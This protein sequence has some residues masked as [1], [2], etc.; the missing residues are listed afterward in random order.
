ML[1]CGRGDAESPAVRLPGMPGCPVC[2]AVRYVRLSGCPAARYA[3]LPGISGCPAAR[4]ARLPGMSGCPVC[5]AVRLP[6]CP[7]CPAVR[8]ARLSGCPA[9]RYARLFD[10]A[11][12]VEGSPTLSFSGAAGGFRRLRQVTARD[13][14]VKN[15]LLTGRA[16]G[17]RCEPCWAAG[18]TKIRH[19]WL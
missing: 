9:A 7:V 12:R 2:P 17:V 14:A 11:L 16:S 1:G 18:L 5:P 4:Y 15:R 19:I 3:R 8:Y 10:G 6:G 13:G